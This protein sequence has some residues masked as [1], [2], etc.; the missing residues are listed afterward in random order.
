MLTQPLPMSAVACM[1][2]SQFVAR[3]AAA[4]TFCP[5]SNLMER[6]ASSI[7]VGLCYKLRAYTLASRSFC[8]L[9]RRARYGFAKGKLAPM[10]SG[11]VQ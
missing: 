8:Y 6:S 11:M 5:S 3:R 1:H 4:D 9:V 10:F 7:S 2:G